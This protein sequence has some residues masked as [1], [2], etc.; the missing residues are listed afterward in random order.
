MIVVVMLLTVTEGEAEEVE[1]SDEDE[2][3]DCAWTK[4]MS[5]KRAQAAS[6][7]CPLRKEMRMVGK[8]RK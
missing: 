6:K 7:S 4:P 8:R 2:S 3:E 1:E 5:A